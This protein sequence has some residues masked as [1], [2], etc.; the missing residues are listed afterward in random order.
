[1]KARITSVQDLRKGSAG[2][3]Y[4]LVTFKLEDNTVARTFLSPDF[5]NY[6]VWKPFLKVGLTLDGLN[7]REAGLINADCHPYLAVHALVDQKPPKAKL[8]ASQATF[9]F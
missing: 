1:M 8:E 7:L 2:A 3:S 9:A 5:R 4:Q 6:Q